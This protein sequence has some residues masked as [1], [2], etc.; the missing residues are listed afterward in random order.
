MNG[1]IKHFTEINHSNKDFLSCIYATNRGFG[2]TPNRQVI[3]LT[4]LA[5]GGK[6]GVENN[7]E[8]RNTGKI[9][10]VKGKGNQQHSKRVEEGYFGEN[11]RKGLPEEENLQPRSEG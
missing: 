1:V 7:H 5:I 10:S 4:E 8:S 2:R 3:A 6:L 9:Q 11:G